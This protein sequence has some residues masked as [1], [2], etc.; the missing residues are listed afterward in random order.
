M[1]SR[2]S[3]T[4][5]LVHDTCS[6]VSGE[7]PDFTNIWKPLS[8]CRMQY[9]QDMR[10]DSMLTRWLS[11]STDHETQSQK[12]SCVGTP[13]RCDE[14]HEHTRLEGFKTDANALYGHRTTNRGEVYRAINEKYDSH[15]PKPRWDVKVAPVQ[16]SRRSVVFENMAPNAAATTYLVFSRAKELFL[17]NHIHFC[18]I[19]VNNIM[20]TENGCLF[21][22]W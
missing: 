21:Q 8:Q 2:A 12:N 1:C 11:Y 15:V 6:K 10:S 3:C 16:R 14:A 20:L 22:E 17:G 18:V 19:C 7:F 5:A 9:L 13:K 4:S